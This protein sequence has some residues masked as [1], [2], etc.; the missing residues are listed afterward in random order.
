M[1]ELDDFCQLR[2]GDGWP[3]RSAACRVR[4]PSLLSRTGA[5]SSNC[6]RLAHE[7]LKTVWRCHSGSS[8]CGQSAF[9]LVRGPAGIGKTALINETVRQVG[10]PRRI[11][12]TL[13]AA[14]H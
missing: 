8:R 10:A 6:E 2:A 13:G 7:A 4:F 9:I 5:A 1:A 14:G 11:L 12:R 3:C